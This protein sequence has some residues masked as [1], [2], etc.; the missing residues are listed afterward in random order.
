[1]CAIIVA[2]SSKRFLRKRNNEA[3]ANGLEIATKNQ[4]ADESSSYARLNTTIVATAAPAKT[5]QQNCTGCEKLSG[6]RNLSEGARLRS[7][8]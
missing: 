4:L 3:R 6:S 5:N 8:K 7:W 2:S 1:M